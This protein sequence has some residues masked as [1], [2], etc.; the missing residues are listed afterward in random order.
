MPKASSPFGKPQGSAYSRLRKLLQ[1]EL[2]SE[3]EKGVHSREMERCEKDPVYWCNTYGYTYD[4]RTESKSMPFK[5]FPK[6]EEFLRWLTER[7]ANKE[8]GLCDKS[9]GVGVSFLCVAYALHGWLFR[10]GYK[11]GFGSRKLEY[12]DKLGDMDALFEKIRFMLFRLPPWMLP[13]GFKPSVHDCFTKLINPDNGAAIT[14]E[15]GDQIGRGGRTSI[16]FVDEAAFL[17]RPLMVERSLS[18]TTN[19]RIDI[20]T[21]NGPGNPFAVKRFSGEVPVFT[22]HWK[23]DPRKD[24]DWAARMRKLKGE[25]VF[26]SE[27]D[28][29]YAAS[30]EG[31]IIPGPWVRAA[32]GL[33]LEPSGQC[34][35]GLDVAEEGTDLSVFT[36]RRGPLVDRPTSWGKALTTETAWRA[37][38]LAHE[39]GAKVLLYDSVGVGAG[40][41]GTLLTSEQ[42]LNFEP[43]AINTGARPTE[44]RWPDGQTS[45]EK[46]ANLKAELW[47]CLRIRFEKAYEFVHNGVQHNP[48]DMISIP[49][50]PQLIAQLSMPTFHRTETGKIKVESKDDLRRRGVKSPDFAESLVLTEGAYVVKKQKFWMR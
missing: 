30:I 2:S 33:A 3:G 40:V 36:P 27:Y 21:P 43:R 8:G 35:A 47:W 12:V 25:V 32:V 13:K 49:D 38:D 29:D 11:V 26:A 44:S 19:V 6:Q 9:R 16:Y 14:G 45:V 18:E 48:E 23:D 1:E 50:D 39:K 31:I 20:S 7:E 37:R 17:E 46:F 15:G 22:F 24:E 34:V 28:I 41:K 5:L 4:P 10:P 42:R